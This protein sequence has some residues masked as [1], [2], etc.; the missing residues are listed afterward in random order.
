MK[1]KMHRIKTRL[2]C[3]MTT[4]WIQTMDLKTGMYEIIFW[5]YNNTKEWLWSTLTQFIYVIIEHKIC[6]LKEQHCR[7]TIDFSAH[8][9][10]SSVYFRAVNR[11]L[12][13]TSRWLIP[14]LQHQNIEN[15]LFWNMR[16]QRDSSIS[17][18]WEFEWKWISV[19][20]TSYR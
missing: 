18:Y 19:T 1:V 14:I 17:F 9:L 12:R 6:E 5:D 3:T 10:Y 20:S 11:I 8:F 2:H 4:T 15:K 7:V 13:T 16:F